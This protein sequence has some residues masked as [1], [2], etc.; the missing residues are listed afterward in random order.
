[1]G[2]VISDFMSSLAESLKDAYRPELFAKIVIII[3]GVELDV[4]ATDVAGF[5]ERV[6]PRG[7]C[8]IVEVYLPY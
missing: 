2:I 1:M 5:T 6:I 8:V 3:V 4:K 7:L